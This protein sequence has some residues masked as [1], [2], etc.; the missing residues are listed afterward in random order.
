LFTDK[1]RLKDK[2]QL[3]LLILTWLN[4]A[5]LDYD[6]INSLIK[7]I[8]SFNSNLLDLKLTKENKNFRLLC[9][10]KNTTEIENLNELIQT[11]NREIEDLN[12]ALQENKV[13]LE[14]LQLSKSNEEAD[15][16]SLESAINDYEN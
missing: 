7:T 5:C 6:S 2:E 8:I 3:K 9:I 4:N 1:N 15:I 10:Q 13:E 16:E 12:K 14:L 11:L